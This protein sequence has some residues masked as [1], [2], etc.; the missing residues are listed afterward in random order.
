MGFVDRMDQ[1]VAKYRIGIRMKKWWWAPFAWMIDVALQN[2]WV[3]H[4]INKD[5]EDVSLSL[6]AFRRDVVNSIFLKYSNEKRASSSRV[7]IRSVPSV[8]RYDDTKHYQVPS[9]KQGRCKVCKKTL[10]AVV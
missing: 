6:L 10:A 9:E 7:R 8:I 2:A 4:R 5:Q 3:L 1:N